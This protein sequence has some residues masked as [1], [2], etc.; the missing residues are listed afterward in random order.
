M[1]TCTHCGQPLPAAV[2]FCAF[3]GHGVAADEY[4]AVESGPPPVEDTM[5]RREP[6]AEDWMEPEDERRR[7]GGVAQAG[8]SPRTRLPSTARRAPQPAEPELR[9]PRCNAPH[10]PGQEYCLE[11]GLRLVPLP[12]VYR[13]MEVWSRDSPVWLWAALAAL[14]LLALVAGA[15]VAAAA[16]GGDDES[17]GDREP[18]TGTMGAFR[19]ARH[20][21][22]RIDDQPHDPH[23]G[24]A[25][26]DGHDDDRADDVTLPTTTT[27]PTTRTTPTTT[28]PS[29]TIS[30]PPGTDGYTVILQSVPTSDGRDE[31]EAKR[32]EACA[33]AFPRS[34]CS[35]RRTTSA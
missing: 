24:H 10:E 9:C 31:A 5:T 4:L 33:R 3:C 8:W 27:L 26:D 30:W 29:G 11:C 1:L 13:R 35:T 32:S 16:A 7:P 34:A 12:P 2:N 15:I 22:A 28:G 6:G 25:P 18:A 19:P 17:S 14:L 23:D 21:H 20:D